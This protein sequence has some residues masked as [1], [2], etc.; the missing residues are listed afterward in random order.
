MAACLT[1]ILGDI[2]RLIILPVYVLHTY[3]KPWTVLLAKVL[4]IASS[5]QPPAYCL[6]SRSAERYFCCIRFATSPFSLPK[7][8]FR[9]LSI[10]PLTRAILSSLNIVWYVAKHK[11]QFVVRP[12]ARSSRRDIIAKTLPKRSPKT[13]RDT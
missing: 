8:T 4:L 7:R 11:E 6:G 13:T 9:D 1:S 3:H 2:D 12:P 5:L 10:L